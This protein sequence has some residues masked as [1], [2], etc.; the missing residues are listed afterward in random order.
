MLESPRKFISWD[1][2][3]D[4]SEAL[5]IKWSYLTEQGLLTGSKEVFGKFSGLCQEHLERGQVTPP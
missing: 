3:P 2:E 5:W 1:A 4:W